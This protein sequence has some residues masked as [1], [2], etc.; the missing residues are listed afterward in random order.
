MEA[1]ES[2][3][4]KSLF[5]LSILLVLVGIGVSIY[6]TVVHYTTKVSLAC[7]ETAVINC[8][9][10]TTSSY[11]AIFGIPLAVLGLLYYVA[12]LPLYLPFVWRKLNSWVLG[13]R[14]ASCI[15]GVLFV[16]W[17]VYVELFKLNSICLYC[18][19]IHVVT[20]LLFGCTMIGTAL[21]TNK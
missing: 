15:L 20:L 16:F 17:L 2:K 12:I 4:T 13:A 14:I 9:K 3:L 19:V 21:I 8:A 1:K 18:T 5:Y 7:P 10:V 6:L 11:S